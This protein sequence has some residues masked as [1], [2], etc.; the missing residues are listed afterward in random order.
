MTVRVPAT[1]LSAVLVALLACEPAPVPAAAPA[2]PSA[3]ARAP[4]Q[5]TRGDVADVAV[6]E[7]RAA[8][9]LAA[10]S[11]EERFLLVIG[12]TRLVPDPGSYAY[13]VAV[14]ATRPTALSAARQTCS[15]GAAEA[16]ANRPPVP[17]DVP[18][19]R[20]GSAPAVGATR[21][22]QLRARGG[23]STAVPTRA[24]AVG[25]SSVVWVDASK[26]HPA[27]LDAAFAAEFLADFEKLILPRARTVFGAESDVDGDGRIALF[28]TP[29]TAEAA[30]A[31][32]SG[33]DLAPEGACPNSNRAEVLYLTPPNAIRPPY[34]TPRAVKEILA[35]ELEHLIHHNRKVVKNGSR[36]DRDSA[37]MLEG[38]GA[39]AQDV[40]GFQAGNLYVTKAGLDDIDDFSLGAVVSEDGE[41]DKARDGALRGGAYLFVRWLYDRAGGDRV[42]PEG[43]IE[44]RG[45]PSLV[46]ALLDAP[47]P[48]AAELPRR[49]GAS[50]SDLM[51]DFYTT[52]GHDPRLLPNPCFTYLPT[53]KDPVT[54]RQ[55]GA[56]PFASFHGQQMEG[57][58]ARKPGGD[59][60]IRA[61]GVELVPLPPPSGGEVAFTV[62]VAT[63]AAA[64]VRVIR[65]R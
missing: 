60:K 42:S 63:E 20:A 61:G 7:G 51:M 16:G 8:A 33:C 50:M 46:R 43:V 22:F 31:F 41:Y 13:R 29:L 53:R 4:A 24:V 17:A 5:L 55:R 3:A 38:F 15:L 52:L 39:L 35:H 28:F 49:A 1:A 56:D 27:V 62:E 54:D 18:R 19:A 65:L 12:S 45:G 25:E 10:P 44:D 64:R 21:T 36:E 57:A 48:I 26:E 40:V 9:R 14:G 2:V 47:A 23:G 32:F 30:V 11:G 37:Y 58:A 34:N 59:G 6:S